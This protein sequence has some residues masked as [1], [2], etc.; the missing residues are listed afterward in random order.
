MNIPIAIMTI[1]DFVAVFCYFGNQLFFVSMPGT[2]E[3]VNPDYPSKVI[4][5]VPYSSAESCIKQEGVLFSCRQPLPVWKSVGVRT[6][7][8]NRP[9]KVESAAMLSK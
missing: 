8:I 5:N 7:G 1:A 9:M 3:T 6:A 4:H 2:V